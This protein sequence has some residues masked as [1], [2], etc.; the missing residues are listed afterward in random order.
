MRIIEKGRSYQLDSMQGTNAQTVEFF[1]RKGVTNREF[2]NA[3]A[4]E[5]LS[6][7]FFEQMNIDPDGLSNAAPSEIDGTTPD[8]LLKVLVAHYEN[9]QDT[10]P[11][12]ENENIIVLLK[13][14]QQEQKNRVLRRRDD[15]TFATL[16]E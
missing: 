7:Y 4:D 13:D 9:F 14:I 11:C 3:R 16:K 8:E 5:D 6:D 15:G 12:D 1:Q 2:H 10:V